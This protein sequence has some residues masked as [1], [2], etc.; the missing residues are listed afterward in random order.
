VQNCYQVVKCTFQGIWIIICGKLISLPW[1]F[2]IFFA[3]GGLC[4]M[5][6][7]ICQTYFDK[8]LHYNHNIMILLRKS[9]R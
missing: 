3:A 6:G 4:C 1:Q 5:M 7:W 2:N 8:E 9:Q